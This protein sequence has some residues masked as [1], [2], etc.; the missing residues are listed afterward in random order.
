MNEPILTIPEVA[1]YL[2]IS[3]SKMYYL[4]QRGTIPHV[5]I[6]RNVRIRKVDLDQWIEEKVTHNLFSKQKSFRPRSLP[7]S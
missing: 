2:K 6:G 7:E 5:R 3:K 4:V 1:E